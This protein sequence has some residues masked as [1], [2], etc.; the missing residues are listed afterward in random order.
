[1][2]SGSATALSAVLAALGRDDDGSA[3]DVPA[4]R[5]NSGMDAAELVAALASAVPAVAEAITVGE[6]TSTTCCTCQTP[7]MTTARSP[8]VAVDVAAPRQ[9]TLHGAFKYACEPDQYG[10]ESGPLHECVGSC[11]KRTPALMRIH[12][13][14]PWP[15]RLFVVLRRDVPDYAARTAKKAMHRVAFPRALDLPLL[16]ELTLGATPPP[17]YQ[18]LGAIVHTGATSQTG[19]YSYETS[20]AVLVS[21]G[22][23]DKLAVQDVQCPGGA[24]PCILVYSRGTSSAP[25]ASVTASVGSGS[26]AQTVEVVGKATIAPTEQHEVASRRRRDCCCSIM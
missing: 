9:M 3:L 13:C 11:Q 22:L 17:D 5:A 12:P 8:L 20:N 24:T 1:M 23:D 6:C 10:D 26:A 15:Q 21:L 16:C 7:K 2:S 19:T 14:A 25:S 18:L 4:A